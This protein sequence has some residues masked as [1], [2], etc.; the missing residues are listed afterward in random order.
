[1]YYKL[2]GMFMKKIKPCLVI[3]DLE[4]YIKLYDVYLSNEAKKTLME[5]ENFAYMC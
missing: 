5:T 2:G 1:M 3:A 4:E